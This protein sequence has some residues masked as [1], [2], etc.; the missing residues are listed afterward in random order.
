MAR[1][2]LFSIVAAAGLMGAM[3]PDLGAGLKI[4]QIP[5]QEGCCA[6][7]YGA[8]T[9]L[10][11]QQ[12]DN[13]S[14]LYEIN[15][16]TGDSSLVGAIG[17]DG[18]SGI[19]FHPTTRV[20]YGA[21]SADEPGLD[22]AVLITIDPLTGIGTLVGEIVNEGEVFDDGATGFRRVPDIDF[23]PDGT[24][25]AH[26]KS[27]GAGG[28]TAL[29]T[30]DLATGDGTY[31]GNT[32][33]QGGG[34]GLAVADDGTI[35]A[36][37]SDGFHSCMVTLDPST[38]AATCVPGDDNFE[39]E[40]FYNAMAFCRETGELFASDIDRGRIVTLERDSGDQ[41]AFSGETVAGLDAIAFDCP[42]LFRCVENAADCEKEA[43]NWC[44]P[45]EEF[46]V[47]A[48]LKTITGTLAKR[49]IRDCEPD[50]F[51]LV[52][53][54]PGE[55]VLSD[56]ND[57]CKGN[58]W[59]SGL[60][61]LSAFGGGFTDN[62]DGTFSL[63]MGV[64]GRADGLDGNMNGLFQNAPHGQK[65]EFTLC[66]TWKDDS[67]D[68]LGD[69]VTLPDG[70]V[71]A[72]PFVYVDEF[73]TGAEAFHINLT[74]PIGGQSGGNP[75]VVRADVCIDNTTGLIQIGDD[76]DVFRLTG[77]VPLCDYCITQIGGIDEH[78]EPTRI[79]MGW[80]D[81]NCGLIDLSNTYNPNFKFD[82]LCVVADANGIVDFFIT[83]GV[84]RDAVESGGFPGVVHLHN[85]ERAPVECRPEV[86]GL[87]GCY[88]LL[89]RG[90]K[91]H[92]GGEPMGE[93]NNGEPPSGGGPGAKDHS[94][95]MLALEH[96]DMNMDG[97][98]NTADL[99]I[100]L[101]WWGWTHP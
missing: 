31:I 76:V 2:K 47:D 95:V 33:R 14:S 3:S 73:I 48:D 20:L 51:L 50:T 82:E 38:G 78:C 83:A 96:G 59:A 11:G 12:G 54:K 69:T 43:N 9:G 80:L 94:A 17:F 71:V 28:F 44:P 67:G 87:V 86:V 75:L 57:S 35:F 4:P 65:G 84:F 77:L 37:P 66:V 74:A 32:N 13:P 88:T 79:V 101:A 8:A 41:T 27:G 15:P 1:T 25:Y 30:V 85:P 98:T 52:F 49:F 7:L 26:V 81:K 24:L 55:I 45:A 63:R 89:I 29:F 99:G 21:A 91:P 16:S 39:G 68:S 61:D 23:A 18:V 70:T 92:G 6:V 36:F 60:F 97:V 93:G 34:N 100:L 53:D 56:D 72:N 64:T 10:E 5:T 90:V 40:V 46:E 19:A 42:R 62:G 58:G 22:R